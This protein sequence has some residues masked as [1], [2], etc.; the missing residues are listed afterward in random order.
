[1]ANSL[2]SSDFDVLVALGNAHFDIGFYEKSAASF[3]TA[4]DVYM[5]A[6]AVKPGDPDVQTDFGLTYFLQEPPSYD[7]AAAELAKVSASHPTHERSLQFLVQTYVKQ[8]KVSEAEKALAK[9]RGVNP[10][11]P[12]ISELSSKISAAR[13]GS[14]Q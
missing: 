14:P 11:N 13:A 12:M 7:K 3:Q 8:N 2:N 6:L 9:L 1:M 5:K 10:A 4:R